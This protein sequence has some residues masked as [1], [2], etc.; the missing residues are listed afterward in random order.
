MAHHHFLELMQQ[1]VD[2]T[3]SVTN[4]C[5]DTTTVDGKLSVTCVDTINSRWQNISY[6]Y[7]ILQAVHGIDSVPKLFN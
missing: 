4:T 6:S 7:L 5:N 3:I 2:G 1:T